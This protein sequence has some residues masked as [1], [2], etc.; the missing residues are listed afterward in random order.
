VVSITPL[1]RVTPGERTPGTHCTGGWV[2]P[3][4]GLDTE[5][6]GKILCPCRGSNP[7]RPVVQPVVRYYEYTDW[8]NPAPLWYSRECI[9]LNLSHYTPCRH[10]GGENVYLLHILDLGTRWS[11][12]SASRP[13]RALA[14]G[15]LPPCQEPEWAAGPDLAQRQEEKSFCLCRGPNSDLPVFQS[16]VRHYTGLP[17]LIKRLYTGSKKRIDRPHTLRSSWGENPCSRPVRANIKFYT[18]IPK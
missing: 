8:A 7:V 15:K 14:P 9:K 4:A 3:R 11:E 18:Q 13:G 5:A 16:V 17:G 2:G 12:F 10:S 6:R 1:P